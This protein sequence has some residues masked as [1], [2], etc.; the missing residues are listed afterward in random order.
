MITMVDM[1]TGATPAM[2]DTYVPQTQSP[3]GAPT[4][5]APP[6][7]AQPPTRTPTPNRPLGRLIGS[8]LAV[9]VA[10][11]AGIG[12]GIYSNAAQP[13]PAVST[14]AAPATTFPVHGDLIIIPIPAVRDIDNMR[15]AG[16]E[17]YSDID[18]G[19]PVVITDGSGATIANTQLT[20]GRLIAS[21]E[22]YF[23]FFA[24]VPSGEESYGITVSQHD[25]VRFTEAAMKGGVRLTMGD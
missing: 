1:S 13:S 15:C 21:G 6:P 10:A 8:A 5:P 11:G 14:T 20:G 16:A 9:V 3:L 4:A 2:R 18:R 25:T 7:H 12:L 17:G 24:T 23:E 19:T 22:C